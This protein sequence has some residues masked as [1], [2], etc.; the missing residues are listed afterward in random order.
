MVIVTVYRL[1]DVF[2]RFS[3]FLPGVV[4]KLFYRLRAAFVNDNIAPLHP[5]DSVLDAVRAFYTGYDSFYSEVP[6]FCY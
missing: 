1:I 5:V 4:F 6:Q 2:A 3:V